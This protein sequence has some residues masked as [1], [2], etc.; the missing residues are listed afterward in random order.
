MKKY[1]QLIAICLSTVMVMAGQ[2]II[3]PVLPLYADS[4]GVS[5]ALV[6]ATFAVFGLARL[7]TNV[8]AGLMADRSGRRRLLVGGPLITAVGMFGSGLAGTIWVLLVFRFVAGL[9]SALYM[10]GATI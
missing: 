6:G 3:S 8:P 9:G 10:T 2:G 5:T 7:V 1:E 4:F